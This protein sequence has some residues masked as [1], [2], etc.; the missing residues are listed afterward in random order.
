MQ[1]PTREGLEAQQQRIE[2][3]DAQQAQQ[4]A[5]AQQQADAQ[6]DAQE[7]ALTGSDRA[8]DVA[9]GNGQADMFGNSPSRAQ[10]ESVSPFKTQ[11]ERVAAI[12]AVPELVDESGALN[13]RG[14]QLAVKPWK[15]MTADERALVGGSR[16]STGGNG[17]FGPIFTQFRHDAQ[18]A[19]EHLRQQQTGEAVAALH[20]PEVGDIDLV[21]GETTDDARAKGK[22]LAKLIRWHP[23]VL[24]DLQG[25]ISRL[26]VKQRHKDTIHLADDKGRAAVKLTW[27]GQQKKWLLSAYEKNAGGGARTDTATVTRRDDTASPTTRENQTTATGKSSPDVGSQ[28]DTLLPGD[29]FETLSGRSTTPFPNYSLTAKSNA[30]ARKDEKAQRR[31]LKENAI[32]EAKANGDDFNLLQFENL[33]VDHWSKADGDLVSLYLFGDEQGQIAGR[34][35][36]EDKA[37]QGKQAKARDSSAVRAEKAKAA[38]SQEKSEGIP[39]KGQPAPA[40]KL[41]YVQASKVDTPAQGS[42]NGARDGKKL[43]HKLIRE[44]R[45]RIKDEPM[46]GNRSGLRLELM[47]A[48]DS[49][50]EWLRMERDAL[51]AIEARANELGQTTI[52][53]SA[54]AKNA[55]PAFSREDADKPSGSTV[56]SIAAA[57]KKAYGNVLDKLQA[58]GLVTLT[59]TQDEAIEAAASARAKAAG[60]TVDEARAGLRS[61]VNN[62]IAAWHGTPHRGI[63]K[64]GFRLNKIGT[65]EGAQAFGWGM[66]FASMREVAEGYRK[67]LS[68]AILVDGKPLLAANRRQAQGTTGDS[69]IDDLLIAHHGDLEAAIAD[70]RE[71][72]GDADT[73]A[74]LEG[75]RGRVEAGNE[76]QLY[77]LDLPIEESDLLDWDKPLSEQPKKV[78]EALKAT[79]PLRVID[80]WQWLISTALVWWQHSPRLYRL[81][82]RD[83]PKCVDPCPVWV[84]DELPRL[85]HGRFPVRG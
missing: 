39:R 29:V 48:E 2:Q 13:Q 8:A 81:A 45:Q 22:G 38:E 30:Q 78:Q 12:K 33:N 53:E 4:R 65:G 68:A 26:K 51:N 14:R 76:G 66:Y 50:R 49:H 35:I 5:Q 31:W 80:R 74:K 10:T 36:S 20:H 34:L 64:T 63:E 54:S 3:A 40:R 55:D 58:N 25:F 46:G 83:S 18:G 82:R 27:D 79:G 52:R 85:L 41:D 71:A 28:R 62:S 32:A 24:D 69:Y 1:Q 21:W 59:Q 17:A 11:A 37:A 9:M 73:L 57:I 44:L 72:G 6:R 42:L 16:E 15:D 60:V 75:L 7:F 23:E 70:E 43:A 84:P 47:K 56:N 61:S 67:D 19:I 77:G